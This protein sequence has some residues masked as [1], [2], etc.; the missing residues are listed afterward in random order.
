[1]EEEKPKDLKLFY[2]HGDVTKL[3]AM[4]DGD[5]TCAVDK[6]TLDAICVDEKEATI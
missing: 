6:G 3:D 1:M 5:F 2:T 4:K